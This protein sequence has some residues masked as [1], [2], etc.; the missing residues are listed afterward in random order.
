[1]PDM[2]LVVVSTKYLRFSMLVFPFDVLAGMN[3]GFCMFGR[4]RWN[5]LHLLLTDSAEQRVLFPLDSSPEC[6]GF[7]H[8]LL[9][10]CSPGGHWHVGCSYNFF[11]FV[12]VGRSILVCGGVQHE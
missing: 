1:M 5:S 2:E 7:A 9:A 4:S 11:G 3:D 6:T 8:I 10:C 12:S